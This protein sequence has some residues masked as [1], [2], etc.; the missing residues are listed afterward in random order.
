MVEAINPDRHV[1]E[2]LARGNSVRKIKI[3]RVNVTPLKHFYKE[4]VLSWREWGAIVSPSVVFRPNQYIKC[5][6]K[7][8]SSALQVSSTVVAAA[9][10]LG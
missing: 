1:T 2:N 9:A 8:V 7:L 3:K 4:T 5:I 10:G 6:E